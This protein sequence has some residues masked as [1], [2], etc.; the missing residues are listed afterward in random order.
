MQTPVA[1][2]LGMERDTSKAE[3]QTAELATQREQL[4]E[5]VEQAKQRKEEAEHDAKAAEL[6]K[7]LANIAEVKLTFPK[8]KIDEL[9][10]NAQNTINDELAIPKNVNAT[11]GMEAGASE[12][13]QAS[14][15]R[16]A[17]ESG[18]SKGQIHRRNRV[19]L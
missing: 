18:H 12:E 14:T 17:D 5:E 16:F 13:Y 19:A 6:F 8:F 11:E 7:E 1:K 3:T 15:H 2:T 4:K 10:T 9:I